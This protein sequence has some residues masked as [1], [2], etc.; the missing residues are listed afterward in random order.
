MRPT[1]GAI[2]KKVETP[3]AFGII[4]ILNRKQSFRI[5]IESVHAPRSAF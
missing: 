1:L 5:S 3:L 2:R 4:F